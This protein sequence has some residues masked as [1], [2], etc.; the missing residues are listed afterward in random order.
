L[1]AWCLGGNHFSD[2][3]S[4]EKI[5]QIKLDY[6]R[7]KDAAGKPNPRYL[8]GRQIL[9]IIYDHYKIAEVNRRIK[10]LKMHNDD[11]VKF[12]DDWL[13]CLLCQKIRPNWEFKLTRCYGQVK[14]YPDLEPDMATCHRFG[15]DNVNFGPGYSDHE[16]DGHG[17]YEWLITC[18]DNLIARKRESSHIN[19]AAQGGPNSAYATPKNKSGKGKGKEGGKGA[20]KNCDFW[21]KGFVRKALNALTKMT[22]PKREPLLVE[23]LVQ[24][25][26]GA[27]QNQEGEEKGKLVAVP[28]VLRAAPDP[29]VADLYVVDDPVDPPKGPVRAVENT[30]SVGSTLALEETREQREARVEDISGTNATQED[31]SSGIRAPADITSVKVFALRATNAITHMS[32]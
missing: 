14:K 10:E 9:K 16:S 17:R 19:N 28:P 31:A 24:P 6:E 18:V 29:Q 21:M 15:Q 23:P 32:R 13:C 1:L 26:Q 5:R 8:K 22:M 2:S 12:H 4:R 7:R 11:L 30:K 3:P 25:L 20:A 27:E